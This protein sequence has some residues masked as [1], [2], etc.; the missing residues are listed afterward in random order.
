MVGMSLTKWNQIKAE[1][2]A[3][4]NVVNTVRGL[5]PETA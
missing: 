5:T 2:V 4:W 1:L 3:M